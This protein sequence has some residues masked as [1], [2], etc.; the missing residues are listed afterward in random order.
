[1]QHFLTTARPIELL[2]L[3][4]FDAMDH[5]NFRLRTS[6]YGDVMPRRK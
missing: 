2:R 6:S 4:K 1:L 5:A 3:A